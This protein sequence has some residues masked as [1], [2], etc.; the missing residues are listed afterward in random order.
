MNN[1]FYNFSSK[2]VDCQSLIHLINLF[3]KGNVVGAEIGVFRAE[4]FCTLLQQCSN[5]SLMYAVDN[6]KPY[7]DFLKMPYDENVPK[8]TVDLKE[9]EYNKLLAYHNIEFC[10]F[11]EKVIFLEK[12]SKLALNDIKNESLDF[13]FI[14]TYMTLDQAREDIRD[15]YP[16]VKQNGLFAGHD[17]SSPQVRQAI[18]EFRNIHKINSKISAFDNTWVW[19]K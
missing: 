6:F 2:E 8:Y 13:V 1:M 10:G 17:W 9:S 15:W 16:K 7:S 3:F 19:I 18:N 14:D 11:K 5:I 12:D 4:S